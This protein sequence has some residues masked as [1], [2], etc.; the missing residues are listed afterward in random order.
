MPITQE[1]CDKFAQEWL[2]AWNSRSIDAIMHH[3]ADS[4]VFSSPFAIAIAPA[5]A[6]LIKV[7]EQL[8][9]YFSAAL[10]KYPDLHFELFQVL[11]GVS[12]V[13]LYYK[14]VKD[15]YAAETMVIKKAKESDSGEDKFVIEQVYCHQ[16]NKNIV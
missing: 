4:I 10:A 2:A 11:V 12:S 7:K 8:R 1:Q 5:S 9:N 14:S 13:V 3:Y 15:L 6:G 16:I